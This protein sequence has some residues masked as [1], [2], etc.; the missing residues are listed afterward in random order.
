MFPKDKDASFGGGVRFVLEPY[1][2]VLSADSNWA[3]KYQTY[4]GHMQVKH[5]LWLLLG[6]LD[7]LI[8]NLI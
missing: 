8:S 6:N 7:V 1:P 5:P 3:T 4:V 2:I